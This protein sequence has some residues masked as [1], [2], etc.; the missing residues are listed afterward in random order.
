MDLSMDEI[1]KSASSMNI[2][3]SEGSGPQYE[4]KLEKKMH[5]KY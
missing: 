1:E 4:D 3:I 5:E 2:D